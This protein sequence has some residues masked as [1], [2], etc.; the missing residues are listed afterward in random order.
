L[1]TRRFASWKPCGSVEWQRPAK[2]VVARADRRNCFFLHWKQ[3]RRSAPSRARGRDARAPRRRPRGCPAL[4]EAAAPEGLRESSRGTREQRQ[5]LVGRR[6]D[7]PRLVG[8]TTPDVGFVALRGCSLSKS[9]LLIADRR[10]LLVG[11]ADRN[12]Q[13]LEWFHPVG[14]SGLVHNRCTA[15]LDRVSPRRRWLRPSSRFPS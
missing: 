8:K 7:W 12:P 5:L 3:S 13:S 6:L 11:R 9:R 14:W 15:P 2:T 4:P 10:Q 1:V